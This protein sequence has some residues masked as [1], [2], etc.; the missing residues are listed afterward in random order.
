[1]TDM[2]DKENDPMMSENGFTPTGNDDNTVSNAE[3]GEM[4]SPETP[5]AKSAENITADLPHEP[6]HADQP[7]PEAPD[8]STPT[9]ASGNP[10]KTPYSGAGQNAPS[11]NGNEYSYRPAQGTYSPHSASGGF[12]QG[13]AQE[14]YNGAHQPPPSAR[15]KKKPP[16][17]KM[18]K[19]TVALLLVV[20]ILV[21][22][23]AGF[24]GAIL[25]NRVLG[26]NGKGLIN[27]GTSSVIHNT[28][29]SNQNLGETNYSV[30]NVAQAVADSVVEIVTEKVTTSSI[31]GQYVEGGAGSGVI[32]TSDGYIIT[33]AHV[34]DGATTI[35]VT[36]TDGTDHEAS[37]IGSDA[38]TDI[39]LLKIDATELTSAVV[40]DSDS[41]I[42]GEPVI[43][44][45]NPLGELGG[46]VT[47][48]IISAL[49]R[50]V[51]IDGT[52]YTLLQTDTAVNSGNSGGALFN[53]N[54]ELI[55]IVNAKQS[56][57]GIEGLG[58]AIPINGA[59]DIVDQLRENGYVKGRPMFGFS[60]YDISDDNALYSLRG[61]EA[62]A[63][64]NYV[65]AY[66]V[67][68]VQYEGG[69]SGDLQ[70]GDR[71]VAIEGVSISG[72]SD[73]KELLAEYSVGDTLTITVSRVTDIRLERAT[74]M[75]IPITLIE[76]TASTEN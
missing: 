27:I 43:A 68:F 56:G 76:S 21:S 11:W 16:M 25:A 5:D 72:L 28:V 8:T 33:C 70:F 38:Q 55:G 41:L 54:G 57:S 2:F 39:A 31:F 3:T 48:G 74:I 66:G 40:G 23:T 32:I 9:Y 50:E 61:S 7:R 60:L 67:Y 51:T 71:I 29:P 24:G 47:S 62:S 4:T 13:D 46:T 65:T 1:M 6:S 18:S 52:T 63:L 59:I 34:I 12:P 64:L 75:D 15:P 10:W 44:I 73:I 17:G 45:G 58:F 37:V 30:A 49:E 36:L 19:G 20:C 35:T 26:S 42:V 69:Q 22:A 14:A 53:I